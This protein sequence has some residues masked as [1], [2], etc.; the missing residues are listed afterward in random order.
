MRW[1]RAWYNSGND[2]STT[3][4]GFGLHDKTLPICMLSKRDK[5]KIKIVV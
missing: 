2:I 5:V 4:K 1:E 3:E